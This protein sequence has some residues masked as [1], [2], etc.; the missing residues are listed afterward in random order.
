MEFRRNLEALKYFGA[1]APLLRE[2]TS[3]TAPPWLPEFEFVGPRQKR[4]LEPA[5]ARLA[6]HRAPQHKREMALPQM[7][8]SVQNWLAQKPL[9]S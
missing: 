4:E 7:V 8:G 2:P 3:T 5:Q 9:H 6:P 1:V